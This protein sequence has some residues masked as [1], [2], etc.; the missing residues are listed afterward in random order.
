MTHIGLQEPRTK[1]IRWFAMTF[2]I[3]FAVGSCKVEDVAF[4]K[5]DAND[6]DSDSEITML[7]SG[8]NISES[9][10]K[11]QDGT[12]PGPEGG[13]ES[14]TPPQPPPLFECPDEKDAPS[15]DQECMLDLSSN[16]RNYLSGLVSGIGERVDSIDDCISSTLPYFL[17]DVDISA[18]DFETTPDS[19]FSQSP[20]PQIC[21]AGYDWNIEKLAMIFFGLSH[22]YY[23][24]P[25]DENIVI[26]CPLTCEAARCGETLLTQLRRMRQNFR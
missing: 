11:D 12:V 21:E 22:F 17:P 8:S 14:S 20:C 13:I 5:V 19:P 15:Q 10:L 6:A 24:D 18:E 26:A 23:V 3:G 25:N 7:D 9:G 4:E 16:D 2:F 1:S